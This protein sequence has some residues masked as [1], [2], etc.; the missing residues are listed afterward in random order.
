M[1]YYVNYRLSTSKP[2]KDLDFEDEIISRY[3]LRSN[4][5]I[6]EQFEWDTQE[7]HMRNFSKNYP[8]VLF[9]IDEEDSTGQFSRSYYR[10]GLMQTIIAEL[11]YPEFDELK[12][13]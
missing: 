5:F 13:T 11:I 4:L 8:E 12:M 10:N 1:G 3:A 6:D 7:S 9:Q 2:E